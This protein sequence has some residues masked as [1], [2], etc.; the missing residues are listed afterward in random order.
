MFNSYILLNH[1]GALRFLQQ[2]LFILQVLLLTLF[3]QNIV[4]NRWLCSCFA[5][6]EFISIHLPGTFITTPSH[7]P[8]EPITAAV[9]LMLPS[10]K[11]WETF[12]LS[13]LNNCCSGLATLRFTPLWALGFSAFS[14]SVERSLHNIGVQSIAPNRNSFSVAPFKKKQLFRPSMKRW[15]EWGMVTKVTDVVRG[16]E[17][18]SKFYL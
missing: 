7:T 2:T 1:F 8:K 9:H 18:C 10:S 11:L 16:N 5:D 6:F 13:V 4:I 12:A 3:N 17:H 14:S 15:N